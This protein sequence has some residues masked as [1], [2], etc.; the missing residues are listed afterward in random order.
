MSRVCPAPPGVFEPAVCEPD[1]SCP[2]V[3][4]TGAIPKHVT[5]FDFIRKLPNEEVPPNQLVSHPHLFG[6]LRALCTR[7]TYVARKPWKL[8]DPRVRPRANKRESRISLERDLGAL[9]S[10]CIMGSDQAKCVPCCWEGAPAAAD[11]PQV[12]PQASKTRRASRLPGVSTGG[13]PAPPATTPRRQLVGTIGG[14]TSARPRARYKG[15]GEIR[16]QRETTY[17]S[18]DVST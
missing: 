12:A 8:I 3:F 15:G 14:A 13:T 16:R 7:A 4:V 6:T 10:V 18:R 2:S 1:V 9:L 11:D 17:V 5:N